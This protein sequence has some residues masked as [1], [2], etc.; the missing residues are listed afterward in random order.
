M[1]N[2]IKKIINSKW[3]PFL[4]L[5]VVMFAIAIVKPVDFGDDSFFAEVLEKGSGPY[6]EVTNITEY[7]GV[8]YNT[9]TSRVIIEFFLVL[10]TSKFS[11]IWRILDS[12]MYVLIGYGIKRVFLSSK[13]QDNKINWIL[14]FLIL[15]IPITITKEAGSIA[16][17]LNYIWPIAFGLIS[18]IPIRKVIDNEKVRWYEYLIYFPVAIFAL[19]SELVCAC[20]LV[21]YLIFTIY[22]AF[23]KKLK[24]II[25]IM[26]LIS[27]VC[28]IVELKC[29]GNKAR[30]KQETEMRFSNFENL[31][32]IDKFALGLIT[33]MN[34]YVLNF[35]PLYFIFTAIVMI[36]I[37]KKYSDNVICKGI[38]A[39]PFAIGILFTLL[40]GVFGGPIRGFLNSGLLD[41]NFSGINSLSLCV[42]ILLYLVDIALSFVSLYLI[43][44]NSKKTLISMLVLSCGLCSRI[45]MGFMPT[46]F[47]SGN[48]TH[49][50]MLVMIITLIMML[51]EEKEKKFK[52]LL[53]DFLIIFAICFK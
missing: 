35:S 26:L 46:V 45:I 17:S 16:T 27:I 31:S 43:F 25:I 21:T 19:N 53:L 10:F 42:P 39:F 14:T 4:V 5:F 37:F 36:I 33:T 50:I 32:V 13:D 23:K 29:P 40:P 9:W 38:G 41:E 12:L 51:I 47:A 48:R 6:P 15:L 11:L 34:Y 3:F 24:P 49:S 18:L 1:F 7:L 52:D 30:T 8:R 2:R 28:M 22:L 44:G 20:I